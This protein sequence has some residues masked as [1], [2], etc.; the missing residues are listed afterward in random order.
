MA[1]TGGGFG[2]DLS[3][4]MAVGRL[5]L[6]SLAYIYARVNREVAATGDYDDKTFAPC[7]STSV[8]RMRGPWT[9]LR[10]RLQDYLGRGA[11]HLEAAGEAIVHVAD[12]YAASDAA[13][14]AAL[15]KAWAHGVPPDF[16][17]NPKDI[18]SPEPLPPAPPKVVLA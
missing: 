8:D 6:P 12:T 5:D 14:Q 9:D 17:R 3:Q 18:R 16:G 7:P 2:A 4:L 13:T 1:N 11:L 15:R 10:D